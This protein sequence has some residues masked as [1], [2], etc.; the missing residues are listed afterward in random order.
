MSENRYV[1]EEEFK[2]A[3]MLVKRDLDIGYPNSAFVIEKYIEQLKACIDNM[4]QNAIERSE[5]D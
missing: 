3:W 2:L 1:T 4:E 5:R